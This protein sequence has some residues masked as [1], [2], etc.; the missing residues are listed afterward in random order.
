MHCD[1]FDSGTIGDS[2]LA[3]H[4]FQHKGCVYVPTENT[5]KKLTLDDA[6]DVAIEAGAEEVEETTDDDGNKVMRVRHCGLSSCLNTRI[7]GDSMEQF[8]C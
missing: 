7:I 1:W 3:L 5:E 6:M 2:G 4:S 8:A